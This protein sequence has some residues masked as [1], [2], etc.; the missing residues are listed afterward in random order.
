MTVSAPA[1]PQTIGGYEI[2]EPLGEGGFGRV[3]R[4]RRAADGAVVA[5][6]LAEGAGAR[7]ALAREAR[8][9][10]R[11]EH[12][13]I[14]RVLEISLASEPPFLALEL[15]E[16][17]D[18]RRLLAREGAL[19][20]ARVADL[21]N[22]VAAALV[23]AHERG[24]FHGDVKPENILLAADGQAKLTDFGLGTERAPDPAAAALS[25]GL[26]SA[27]APAGTSRYMAPEVLE[28]APAT[29][30]ADIYALGV[31]IFEMLTGRAPVGSELPSEVNPAVNPRWDEIFR[32]C[33]TGLA[34]RYD[35]VR[36]LQRDLRR[37]LRVPPR[38]DPHAALKALRDLASSPSVRAEYDQAMH[39]PSRRGGLP[40]SPRMYIRW[41]D[42]RRVYSPDPPA[43]ASGLQIALIVF[44][45]IITVL[46][47]LGGGMRRSRP[48]FTYYSTY[49]GFD[50]NQRWMGR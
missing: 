41:V 34:R 29:P 14:V 17:G 20:P 38:G 2:L 47:L 35:S 13:A 1:I 19:A 7:A 39:R 22:T 12:A 25:R 11:L 43:N 37:Q 42:G 30:R 5:L 48:T 21:A 18:L 31:V 15:C 45:V 3:F 23:F 50:S 9:A 16:G 49:P 24:V 44:A 46:V 8:V 33:Y 26:A 10:L 36:T 27:A 32:R 4:A 28:G 6:K 40:A